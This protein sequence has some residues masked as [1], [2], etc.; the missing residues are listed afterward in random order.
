MSKVVVAGCELY[1]EIVDLTPPWIGGAPTIL[2]H[3][4]LGSTSG[5]WSEWLPALIDRFR[6]LR[7]DLRGHGRSGIPDSTVPISLDGLADDVFAVADEA[8]VERFHLVGESIGGTIAINAALHQPERILTLTVS[9]GA[10]LGSSIEAVRDWQ[11]IIETSGMEAWS[12]RMM[13]CRFFDGTI[14]GDMWQWYEREQARVSP[15]FLLDALR[16]LVGADLSSDLKLL[17]MPILLMHGDS[18]PFIPIAVMAD[19][20]GKLQRSRLQIFAH[21]R[22]G[23]P[24]SHAKECAEALRRFL[25]EN[26]AK[27]L[28]ETSY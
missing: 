23:L 18:S 25:D 27:V 19:L 10:H 8:G 2:F 24:F 22:H 12:K 4:G 17:T 6:I 1:Y 14:S 5:I 13:R 9:N 7:F 11:Q 28:Y 21:A 16:V 20:K 26:P 3:H 15:D